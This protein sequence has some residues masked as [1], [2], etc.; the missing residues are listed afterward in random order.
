MRW[1]AYYD[2]DEEYEKLPPITRSRIKYRW[3]AKANKAR[4]A[5]PNWILAYPSVPAHTMQMV[6]QQ[7]SEAF[8]ATDGRFEAAVRKR[9]GNR[10]RLFIRFLPY[11]DEELM[12]MEN[13]DDGAA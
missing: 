10:Y 1:S 3:K 12:R 5:S 7:R 13:N 2:E 9:G 6:N 11:S 4:N 8:R